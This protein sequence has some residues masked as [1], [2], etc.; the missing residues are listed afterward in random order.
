LIGKLS[1]RPDNRPRAASKLASIAV[2]GKPTWQARQREFYAPAAGS[3]GRSK[4]RRKETRYGPWQCVLA[5]TTFLFERNVRMGKSMFTIAAGIA[6][7]AGCFVL[8]SAFGRKADADEEQGGDRQASGERPSLADWQIAHWLLVDNRGE[9]ALAEVAEE[10]ASNTDVK[11][12]AEQIRDEH[13]EFLQ[14]LEQ[15]VALAPRNARPASA[16]RANGNAG[17]EGL[18]IVAVKQQIGEQCRKSALDELEKMK[19][20]A[21]DRCY[22]GLQIGMH[23]HILDSLKVLSRYASPELDRL[24]DESEDS[25]QSHLE[26][27]KRLMA[28]LEKERQG[29]PRSARRPSRDNREF[30]FPDSG[31]NFQSFGS[32]SSQRD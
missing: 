30:G 8:E 31:R 27:A 9:I 25:A 6:L 24:I 11:K 7:L 19:G 15:I 26:Q 14:Q 12:F 21:F 13:Q 32:R 5:F 18:D 4:R 1:V 28:A 2:L 22:V 10:S 23:M 16:A 17:E 3:G 29:G 20:P